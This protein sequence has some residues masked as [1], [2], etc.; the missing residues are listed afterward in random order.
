MHITI[1]M[2]LLSQQKCRFAVTLWSQLGG[3]NVPI[4][5]NYILQGGCGGRSRLLG[6][7]RHAQPAYL[8]EQFHGLD[9]TMSSRT[10]Q[11]RNIAI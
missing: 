6:E 9:M 5:C 8:H 7:L 1:G 11:W 10:L 3:S 2:L 4:A